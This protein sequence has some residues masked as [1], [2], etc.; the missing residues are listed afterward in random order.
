MWKAAFCWHT[1]DMDLYSI[2]YIHFGAPKQWSGARAALRRVTA[3]G[4]PFRTTTTRSLRSSCGS[5]L[6]VAAALC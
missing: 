2:N 3:A 5:M 4:T 6:T 1:E